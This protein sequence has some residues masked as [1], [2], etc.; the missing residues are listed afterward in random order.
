M[1]RE[2]VTQLQWKEE[3]SSSH[4]LEM[5]FA[6]LNVANLVMHLI[7]MISLRRLAD[8]LNPSDKFNFMELLA[9]VVTC[10]K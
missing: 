2:Y 8:E 5:W 9:Q 4:I 3:G 6:N 7:Q 1:G 10:C